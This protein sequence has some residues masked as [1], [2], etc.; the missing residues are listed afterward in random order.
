MDILHRKGRAL[1]SVEHK[2]SRFEF[3][4]QPHPEEK[5]ACKGPRGNEEHKKEKV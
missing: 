3:S 5:E 1:K 2:H 4:V